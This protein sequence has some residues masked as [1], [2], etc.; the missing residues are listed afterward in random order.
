[1]RLILVGFGNIGQSVARQL[2]ERGTDLR[3]RYGLSPKVVAIADRG[4][5]ASDPAGLDLQTALECKQRART[6]AAYPRS[7]VRN[8]S[9]KDMLA[10]CEAEVLVEATPTDVQSGEPALSLLKEALRRRLH[11]VTAN[12]GPLAIAFPVLRELAQFNGVQLKF[13]ATVGGGTPI[14]DFGRECLKGDRIVA[15]KGVLNGTTNYI[16][17]RMEERGLTSAA[18]LKE[19]RASGFAEADPSMDIDGIDTAAKLVILANW[20]LEKRVTLRDVAIKGIRGVRESDVRRARTKG[21][22]IR[23]IGEAD[24][25]GLRV[26]P[27]RVAA[28]H[29]L[30]IKGALNAVTFVSAY[31]GEETVVGKGAGGME[32][33]SAIVRD[34][35]DIQQVLT[36]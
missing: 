14:L 12:K 19:A 23:L 15:V 2:L 35:L 31:A 10:R 9:A 21:D 36:S 30:S 8:G 4:G 20:V 5:Q 25:G 32:T 22:V 13:S 33:A 18:A 34:L 11:V 26:A 1:M 6:I 3:H 28:T 27:Q 24:S 29:P 17:S 7:G 16:L